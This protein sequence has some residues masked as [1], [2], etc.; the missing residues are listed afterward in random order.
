MAK[1]DASKPR[2][3]A[4][5]PSKH[6]FQSPAAVTQ[7]FHKLLIRNTEL[8]SLISSS[9]IT[10]SIDRGHFSLNK[11][12]SSSNNTWRRREQTG[13]VTG[14][15]SGFLPDTRRWCRGC[16]WCWGCGAPLLRSHSWPPYLRATAEGWETGGGRKPQ[17]RQHV[18]WMNY[19]KILGKIEAYLQDTD[20]LKGS[21]FLQ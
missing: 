7:I 4:L 3:A 1:N 17:S 20:I 13:Q 14:E 9:N 8:S 16:R 6:P 11:R 19:C 5:F 18:F 15:Q 10:I 2:I 21:F 12:K